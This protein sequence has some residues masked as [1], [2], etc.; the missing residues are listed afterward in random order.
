[1]IK[2]LYI[3]LLV[4]L[5]LSACT[6]FTTTRQ[7]PD[8]AATWEKQYSVAILPPEVTIDF[9]DLE[10]KSQPLP[11]EEVKAVKIIKSES[12]KILAEKGYKPVSFDFTSYFDKYPDYRDQIID[13]RKNIKSELKTIEAAPTAKVE[14]SIKYSATIGD[15]ASLTSKLSKADL[16]LYV[17]YE[18][19]EKSDGLRAANFGMAVLQ[20]AIIGQSG[21]YNPEGGFFRVA[22]IEGAT[23]NIMW[24]NTGPA[25][26]PVNEFDTEGGL[27]AGVNP[28][29]MI[30]A[31]L[32]DKSKP[33]QKD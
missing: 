13:L 27:L 25:N 31:E 19:F 2:P 15:L 7:N 18:G 16:L 3:F 14:D 21:Q 22:L 24:L 12:Q 29:K 32:P 4:P 30:F 6:S 26:Q 28:L 11:D 9:I 33:K 20:Q 1:M 10:G 23:G 5:F 17:G 8:F